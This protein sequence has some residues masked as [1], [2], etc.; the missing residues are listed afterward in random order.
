[1]TSR[2]TRLSRFLSV[3]A[4]VDHLWSTHIVSFYLCKTLSVVITTGVALCNMATGDFSMDDG[5]SIGVQVLRHPIERDH[6]LAANPVR[7]QG[8][9]LLVRST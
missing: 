3:H 8:R 5:V 7:L 2:K 1:M 6:I 9:V 4:V